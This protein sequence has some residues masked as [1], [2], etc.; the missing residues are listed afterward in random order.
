MHF[1]QNNFFFHFLTTQDKGSSGSWN[2]VIV[3]LLHA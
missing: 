3:Q 1:R 2:K